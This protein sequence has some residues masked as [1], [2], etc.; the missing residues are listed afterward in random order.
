MHVK[1]E[2]TN[3]KKK[4]DKN[5]TQRSKQEEE[6]WHTHTHMDFKINHE[7]LT[8]YNKHLSNA[9]KEF[10]ESRPLRKHARRSREIQ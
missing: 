3:N 10:L 2:E 7:E 6:I 1:N 9:N 5:S 4:I 8:K